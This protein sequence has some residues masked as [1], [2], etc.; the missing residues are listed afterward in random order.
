M[1]LR[2]QLVAVEQLVRLLVRSFGAKARSEELVPGFV[3]QTKNLMIGQSEVLLVVQESE[4]AYFECY[5]FHLRL[6]QQH[7]DL[8]HFDLRV[9]PVDW[10]SC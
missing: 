5:L 2:L 9:M 1:G 6:I 8:Q 7:F 3:R 4:L 10:H